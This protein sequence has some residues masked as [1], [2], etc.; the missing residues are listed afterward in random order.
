[1]EVVA[2][3][4][5]DRPSP[6]AQAQAQEK[7]EHRIEEGRAEEPYPEGGSAAWL[8]V[9]GSFCGV[10]G[11]FGMMNS[12]GICTCPCSSFGAV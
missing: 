7:D 6:Q 2:V 5:Q 1:M 12:I 11:A 4:S 3:A 10:V 8:V 9:L